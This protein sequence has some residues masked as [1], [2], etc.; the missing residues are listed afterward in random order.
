[1]INHIYR[2]P[3]KYSK[4]NA[5]QHNFAVNLLSKLSFNSKSRVLDIGCGDG[6]ITKEIAR[7]VIDGCVIGTDISERMSEFASKKYVNQAN[8]RFLTMD[9]STNL[10][11]EQFDIVTSFNCLHWVKE[12]QKALFGI[13]KSAVPGAQVALLLSH[14]KS[15]Y[16]LVL[17]KICSSSMWK[18]YFIYFISPRSFF[19]PRDYKEMLVESGLEVIELCDEKMTCSFKSK[20]QLQD[21][22]HAAGA[23]IKQIPE[24]KKSEFL[25]EFVDEYLKEAGISENNLIP[26]SFWCLQVIATKPKLIKTAEFNNRSTLFSKL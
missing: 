25:N 7:I 21:F 10:F 16:H 1:M 22:F 23:Q 24:A 18:N 6:V 4:N 20:V 3:I 8:L 9:A 19:E 12:Q 14:K 2:N 26:V 17:D 13:A 5:L 11:R 15:L